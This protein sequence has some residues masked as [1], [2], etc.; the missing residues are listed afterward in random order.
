MPY[1]RLARPLNAV[2]AGLVVLTGAWLAGW[3]GCPMA[4]IASLSGA[5]LIA[6]ANVDNDILDSETDLLAHP[7][8]PIPKGEINLQNA[9]VFSWFLVIP[10]M[11]LAAFLPPPCIM[12]FLASAL[13]TACYNRILKGLTLI[14]NIAVSLAAALGFL[15]GGF[16]GGDLRAALWAFLLAFSYHMA[17]EAVKSLEDMAGDRASGRRTVP[18][19][20]GE[21]AGLILATVFACIMMGITPLPFLFGHLGIGYLIAVIALVDCVWIALIPYLW[22]RRDYRAVS[23]VAKLDMLPALGALVLGKI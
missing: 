17:R 20:W 1:L 22:L 19:A 21:R 3:P 2:I 9:R 15:F 16:L 10:A 11:A 13:I 8:R 14:S 12:V 18:V 23:L 4:I 5:L 7:E 6:W